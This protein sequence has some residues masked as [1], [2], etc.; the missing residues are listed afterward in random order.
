[1]ADDDCMQAYFG[2]C[3][4]CHHSCAVIRNGA[5]WFKI[6]LVKRNFNVSSLKDEQVEESLD[7][8]HHFLNKGRC[9]SADVRSEKKRTFWMRNSKT[10]NRMNILCQTIVSRS[11]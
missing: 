11:M 5:V 9:A 1:M 4:S 6:D 2:V 10:Y 7:P 8:F 3:S